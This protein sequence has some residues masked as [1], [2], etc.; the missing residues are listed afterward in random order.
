MTVKE[1]CKKYNGYATQSLKDN[2]INDNLQVKTYIPF[3]EK[4]NKANRIAKVTTH[5]YGKDGKITGNIKADST[6]RYLLFTLNIID[7]YTALDIDF[8]NIV[9]EFDMLAE[10][11][12]IQEILSKI[13]QN[14]VSDFKILLDMSVDDIMTNE[15][16]TQAFISEQVV[17]F[18][19][20][21]SVTLKPVLDRLADEI[22]NLDNEKVNK[23]TSN[24]EEM[25]KRIK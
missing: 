25:F 24:I 1:F 6:S 11:G 20:I 3:K 5:K 2:Y 21:V 8:K 16:S 7:A 9:A 18:G 23:L 15:F 13:P 19:N 14:E 10:N 17:R 22:E 12:L 4:L